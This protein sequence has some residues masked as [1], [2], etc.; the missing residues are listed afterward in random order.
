M[1]WQKFL[2]DKPIGYYWLSCEVYCYEH[3]NPY[4]WGDFEAPVYVMKSLPI[5][6]SFFYPGYDDFDIAFADIRNVR[7]I[8]P[9]ENPFQKEEAE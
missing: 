5:E 9:I 7:L 3:V 1:D 4:G 8:G 6:Y 2:E